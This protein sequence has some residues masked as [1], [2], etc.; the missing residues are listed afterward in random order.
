[1][2]LRDAMQDILAQVSQN[3]G[4]KLQLDDNG[5]CSPKAVVKRLD[6]VFNGAWPGCHA[7][8]WRTNQPSVSI[9]EVFSSRSECVLPLQKCAQPAASELPARI[10]ARMNSRFFEV[11]A[12]NCAV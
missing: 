4:T 8:A 12:Q 10:R 7:V 2:E 11:M 1:M 9:S 6:K 5:V 3:L